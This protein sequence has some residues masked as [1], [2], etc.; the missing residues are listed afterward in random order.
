MIK[1]LRIF[2]FVWLP[3]TPIVANAWTQVTDFELGISAADGFGYTGTTVT[4]TNTIS[5]N[6]TYSAK[7]HFPAGDTCWDA[8]LTCGAFLK[9]PTHVGVGQ[10]LWTRAYMYFPAGW[11]WGDQS[12][13]GLWRKIMRYQIMTPTGGRGNIEVGGVWP[14]GSSTVSEIVGNTEAGNNYGFY[15]QFT[16]VN[17]PVGRWISVEQYVKFGTTDAT[18]RHMIWLDGE[19]I[20]DSL[21]F[22]SNNPVLGSVDDKCAGVLLFTY[23]NGKVRTTQDAYLDNIISTTDTPAATDAYGQPMIGPGTHGDPVC[24]VHHLNLCSEAQCPVIGG[25]YCGGACQLV[26]CDITPITCG[27]ANGV[28]DGSETGVDCGGMCPNCDA[29]PPGNAG[30]FA[31]GLMIDG[32]LMALPQ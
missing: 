11:D 12:G 5:Q 19:R 1:L 20:F 8:T 27:A 2:L 28:Q 15:D 18:T 21:N 22:P 6:G 4:Q 26:P 23:W 17:F 16:G 10:E 13:G 31:A 14:G 30:G 32:K 7:V 9:M 24:D 29:P 3:L 25:Y